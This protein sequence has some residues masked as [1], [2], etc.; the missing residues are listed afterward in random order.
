MEAAATADDATRDDREATS[1]LAEGMGVQTIG[2]PISLLPVVMIETIEFLAYAGNQLTQATKF[3]DVRCGLATDR[4]R[5]LAWQIKNA[6]DLLEV[7]VKG[8]DDPTTLDRDDDEIAVVAAPGGMLATIYLG[9]L[10]NMGKVVATAA[11]EGDLGDLRS[12]QHALA[13]FEEILV[14]SVP[15]GLG[16]ITPY[17]WDQSAADEQAGSVPNGE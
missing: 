9:C 5:L 2:V 7:L 16:G 6:R 3:E 4:G 12:A 14:G 10:R 11:D 1:A 17:T 15:V 13:Y 8:I